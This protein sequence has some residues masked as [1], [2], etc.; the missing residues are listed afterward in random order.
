[1]TET[2]DKDKSLDRVLEQLRFEIELSWKRATYFSVFI[3]GTYAALYKIAYCRNDYFL[4]LLICIF[5]VGIALI[6]CRAN[7]A[8][9]F[10]QKHWEKRLKK[11][12]KDWEH[13]FYSK[14][15]KRPSLGKLSTALILLSA[16]PFGFGGIYCLAK[17][18]ELGCSCLIFTGLEVVVLI[19]SVIGVGCI[20]FLT[21]GGNKR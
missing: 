21:Q 16:A 2:N 5:G 19:I 1:M 12:N 6:W 14:R 18:M 3:A 8:N 11:V 13:R 7:L 9:I 10:W 17:I 15:V 20:P 4:G